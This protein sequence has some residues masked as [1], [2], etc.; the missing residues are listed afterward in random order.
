MGAYINPDGQNKEEWLRENGTPINLLDVLNW[1][2]KPVDVLPVVLM[3][4]GFFTAA[5]ICYSETEM[6]VFTDPSDS[7]P[8]S[9][10]FVNTE[11]LYGVSNLESY[12]PRGK[13]E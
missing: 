6:R 11:K 7:R 3:N 5:G 1:S 8:K 12:L 4:N 13:D 2:H 9:Y 10:F